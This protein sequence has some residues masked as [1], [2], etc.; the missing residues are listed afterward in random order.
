MSFFAQQL[1]SVIQWENPDPAVLYQRW[2]ESGDEIKN[3]SKLIVGPG[4]GCVFVVEGRVEAVYT[5]EGL[6][7]LHTA[8]QPFF[9]TL[10]RFMQGFKSEHKVGIYFFRTAK[11]LNLKW[12]TESQIKYED[13]KYKFPVSLRAFGNYAMRIV[14]PRA[15][16]VQVVGGASTFLV[17]HIREPLNARLVQPLTDFF[18]E[19]GY[20]YTQIDPQREE[21]ATALSAKLA[22][23]FTQLG[24]LLEDFRI[25]GTSFDADTMR[26]I[27]RIADVNAE[28]Q[29]ASAAGVSYAQLQQLEALREAAKNQGSGG[30]AMAVGLGMAG[31]V[32]PPLAGQVGAQ[33]DDAASKLKKLKA[34]LDQQLITQAEYDAK[35]KEILST[36]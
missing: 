6:F 16:F 18:A 3:A 10:S 27:G 13:P 20:T 15:F 8:N 33:P 25:Q 21:I 35:K 24:F 5:E 26:R 36:L 1:R 28:A 9:T 11:I 4:Q 12:G 32:L 29:A 31:A 19:A 30:M 14:D 34:L 2:T 7:E 22:Q 23:E 17:E